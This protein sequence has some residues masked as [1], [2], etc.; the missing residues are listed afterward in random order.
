M[1]LKKYGFI[2]PLLKILLVVILTVSAGL[3]GQRWL[4]QSDLKKS[5]R[6]DIEQALSLM[7]RFNCD[8]ALDKLKFAEEKTDNISSSYDKT[9]YLCVI[10]LNKGVCHLRKGIINRDKEQINKSIDIFEDVLTLPNVKYFPNYIYIAY[11]Y[12][13]IAKWE[14]KQLN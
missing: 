2:I 11:N 14:L 3:I 12:S 7:E 4:E 9:E 10:R 1:F 5:V 13:N 6:Y 8:V